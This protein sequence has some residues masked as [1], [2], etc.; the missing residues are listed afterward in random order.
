MNP[1]GQRSGASTAEIFT[2]DQLEAHA[3]RIAATHALASNPR[4]ARPLL[5]QLD[6]SADRLDEAYLFLS[7]AARDGRAAGRRRRVAA[8]QPPCR[9]GP[10]PRGPAAPAAQVLPRAAEAGR[11]PV[12]GLSA[13]LPA[14]PRADRAHRRPHR[15]RGHRRLRRRA[16]QRTSP[17]SIGETW[18]VPIM[19]RLALV[20]ELAAARRRRRRRPPAP[21]RRRA[22]WHERLSSG[23]RDP[24]SDGTSPGCSTNGRRDGRAPV[25][26]LRR[27]AA[28]VAARPAVHR[29][30][31]LAGAASRR[32]RNRTTRPTRCCGSSTSARRPTSSR[33][34]T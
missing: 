4:R 14:R 29:R 10:G 17:L 6:R 16:Y 2:P 5:P 26:R 9:P 23:P 15:P 25:A 20:E 18:A 12:P 21:R 1:S 30:G 11:R 34:A 32:S 19:L 7:A 31:D 3:A 22:R 27:R 33:S 8:R 13:R 28:A 24:W